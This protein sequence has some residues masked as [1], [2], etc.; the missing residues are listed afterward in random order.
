MRDVFGRVYFCGGSV[1]TDGSHAWLCPLL[2]PLQGDGVKGEKGRVEGEERDI[3]IDRRTEVFWE[4]PG[5]P[6]Q[7]Q[8]ASLHR[9]SPYLRLVTGVG[10]G[11]VMINIDRKTPALQCSSPAMVIRAVRE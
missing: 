10:E 1:W 7:L 4:T 9:L 11:R 8:P 3:D 6:L 5:H 2:Q